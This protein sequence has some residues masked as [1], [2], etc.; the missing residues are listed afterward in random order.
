MTEENPTIFWDDNFKGEAEGGYYIRSEI[1]NFIDL[2]TKKGKKVV[3]IRYDGTYTLEFIV[4]QEQTK[5]TT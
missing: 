1:K 2:L 5:E 4:E 3:G